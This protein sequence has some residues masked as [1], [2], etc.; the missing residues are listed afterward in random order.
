MSERLDERLT[1]AN[2]PISEKSAVPQPV[3]S[4]VS[5]LDG[6]D[7]L[8]ST[9]LA[10]LNV[11]ELS[12]N[13]E[14]RKEFITG[15][16]AL[17]LGTWRMPELFPVQLLMADLLNA[18]AKYTTVLMPRRSTKTTTLLAWLIGRCLS[19]PGIAIHYTML[20]SGLKTSDRFIRDVV[21]PMEQAYPDADT[22][23]FRVY[24][25]AGRQA[26]HFDNG[27]LFMVGAPKGDSYRSEAFDIIALDE[28]GEGDPEMVKD[29]LGA[30]EPTML[31][32]PGSML[33]VTGTAG[34]YRDGN[35]LFDSLKEAREGEEDTAL[36]EYAVPDSTDAFLF[37]DW[38]TTAPLVEQSHPGVG[39]SIALKDIGA[40]YRRLT[41]RAQFAREFLGVFGVVGGASFISSKD[42][43]AAAFEGERPELPENFGLAFSI[44]H[45]MTSAAICAAWRE[46]GVAYVALL[47]HGSGI[48]WVAEKAL[49]ISRKHRVPITYDGRNSNELSEVER[50]NRATPRPKLRPMNTAEVSTATATLVREIETRKLKHFSQPSLDEA[51]R[52][53]VKR[54]SPRTPKWFLGLPSNGGDITPL[55]AAFAALAAYDAKPIRRAMPKMFGT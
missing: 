44:S 37:E 46:D 45:N 48:D 17:G 43:E 27:S 7:S 23:P 52:I 5:I 18:G 35:L 13:V 30:A 10:P 9:A 42:W 8:R 14:D 40:I 6:W 32:R 51:A 21:T 1:T 38:E 50:L 49:A 15:A 54:G 47:E 53:V 2:D 39:I 41:D 19:R 11:S 55:E 4:T 22:R 3:G 36:L 33:L 24:K 12:T 25:G 34:K 16:Q 20:T 31:T 29:I 28:A 26:I